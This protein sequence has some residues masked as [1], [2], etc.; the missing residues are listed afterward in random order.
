MSPLL[1]YALPALSS[2]VML[3]TF[4][5]R[6]PRLL[7]TPWVSAFCPHLGAHR[8]G[9]FAHGSDRHMV[10]LEDV[11]RRFPRMPMS[12]EVKEQNEELIRKIAGLV[13]HY[14]C[15]EITIWASEKS[16][17]MKKCKAAN[18]EMPTA[19]TISRGFWVLLLYYLG[20]LPFISIPERFLIS[21]LPTIINRLI[22]RKS[23]IQHLE[24]RGVQVV[25]WC[26]NEESDFEVAFCLGATGVITDY[27][28]ALRRYLDNHGPPAVAS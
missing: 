24:Q 22:M 18:P 19:F 17:V 27:P 25:F 28:T 10:R 7:H 15:D 1:Y 9:H 26:L 14:E 8:G 4:F 16:S 11:F 12:V 13:R 3:S 5:L 20:L 2:Y 21:F 23:L 6:R